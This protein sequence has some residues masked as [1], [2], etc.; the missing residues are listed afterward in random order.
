MMTFLIRH[1]GQ[2]IIGYNEISALSQTDCP[3][4]RVRNASLVHTVEAPIY[5]LLRVTILVMGSVP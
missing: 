4:Y 1:K 3:M 5:A 2:F